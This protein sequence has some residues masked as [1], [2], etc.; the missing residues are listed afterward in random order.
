MLLWTDSTWQ[1][2]GVSDRDGVLVALSG[3]ADS[4]ALLLELL[5]LQRNRIVSRVEAAHLH[6]GIRG[7]DADED[8]AFVC[9]L[10]KRLGV[11][12]TSERV[13]VPELAKETGVSLELAA[14]NVRYAFLERVRIARSLDCIAVGHHRDDQAE[15]LLL[16]LLRGSGTDGLAGMRLRSDRLIRPLLFTDKSA[17]LTFLAEQG[18]DY[19]TDASNYE[20]DATRNRIRLNVLPVLESINP[21]VK[22]ALS[23]ASAHI[24]EDS[25]YLNGIAEHEAGRCGADR[26]KLLS[27]P[28]PIRMRVLRN[29]LPYRDYTSADVDRLDMLLHS[30]QT[31][32]VA[33]MKYGVVAWLDSENLR[34]GSPDNA[35]YRIGIPDIGTVKLPNGTLTVESVGIASVP[36]GRNDAY[37]DSDRLNGS[38]YV[39]NPKPGDRFTPFGMQGSRLLSDYLTDRKVP[40]FDRNQPVVCDETG[41]VFAVGHTIDERMRVSADTKH[42]THY[43]YEED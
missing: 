32:D 18:Q 39:R 16:H 25:A 5:R 20:T 35:E 6:H 31:G 34:F 3:G 11:P 26:N 37:I 12:L 22:K 43:H 36:C 21:S 8:A 19:R 40:R 14:R 24:A 33:T 42:I 17:I 29:M 4:V 30:G 2:C 27:L 41:I 7:K 13:D 1:K 15:T 9:S 38:V 23:D 10:C 28:R